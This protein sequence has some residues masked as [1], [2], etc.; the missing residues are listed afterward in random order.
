MFLS[1]GVKE[2]LDIGWNKKKTTP[3]THQHTSSTRRGAG[4]SA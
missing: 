1:T 4:A 2:M 3:L